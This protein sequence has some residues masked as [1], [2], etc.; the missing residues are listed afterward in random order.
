MHDNGCGVS[1]SHVQILL[2]VAYAGR[3]VL[4]LRHNFIFFSM[5]P[6]CN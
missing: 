3:K 6:E 1:Y 4:Q 2:S 5:H